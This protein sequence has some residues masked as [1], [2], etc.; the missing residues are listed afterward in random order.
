MEKKSLIE[1][2]NCIYNILVV[3]RCG[4]GKSSFIKY[5]GGKNKD[6]NYP[7]TDEHT[8]CGIDIY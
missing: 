4:S 7:I 8:N 5:F 6:G 1:D 2:S 3:G